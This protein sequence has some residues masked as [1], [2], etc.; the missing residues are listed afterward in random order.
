MAHHTISS[1]VLPL[2]LAGLAFHAAALEIDSSQSSL[3]VVS[4]KTKADGASSATEVFS[5]NSLTGNVND[6]GMA[7]VTIDLA[8]VAK[9]INSSNESLDE[10]L[11]ETSR[12]SEATLSAQVPES[13]LAIGSHVINLEVDV[14]MHG[15]QVTYTV[16]VMI[17]SGDNS[18][19]VASNEPLIVDASA[20][21]LQGGLGKLGELAA[22]LRIPV[23]VPITFSLSFTR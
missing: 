7:S 5:F 16:P 9:G 22:L 11:F 3:S 1:V 18:V 10:P 23:T 12:Y 2:M 8:S 15:N 4:I 21:K 19:L 13:A 17:T 20:F 6:D 14:D